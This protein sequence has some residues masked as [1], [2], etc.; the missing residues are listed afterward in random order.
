MHVVCSKLTIKT[1]EPQC[2]VSRKSF[3]TNSSL[4]RL[5][6]NSLKVLSAMIF[7]VDF[8][9]I[10]LQLKERDYMKLPKSQITDK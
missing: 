10:A 3:N 1:E 8:F 2:K 7:S 9:K 5:F 4:K 6:E